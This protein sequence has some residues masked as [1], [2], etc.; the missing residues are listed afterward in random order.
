MM[1][2]KSNWIYLLFSSALF[3]FLMLQ[4]YDNCTELEFGANAGRFLRAFCKPGSPCIQGSEAGG[5]FRDRLGSLR[6]SLE[7]KPAQCSPHSKGV[8]DGLSA[9][10]PWTR[11]MGLIN[12]PWPQSRI[13]VD[14]LEAS[15]AHHRQHSSGLCGFCSPLPGFKSQHSQLLAVETWPSSSVPLS[16]SFQHFIIFR[17]YNLIHCKRRHATC[18]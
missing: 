11:G 15:Q 7:K 9:P 18:K 14:S 3:L 5:R 6:T 2:Q 16:V 10:I 13:H 8:S 4:S 12:P 1:S 17:N